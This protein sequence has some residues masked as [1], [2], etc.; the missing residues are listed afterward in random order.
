MD[1]IRTQRLEL[2]PMCMDYL[3]STHEYAGDPENTTYMMYLPN[4]TLED[5]VEYIKEAETE[6]AKDRPSFYEMAIFYNGNHIGAVSLYL[7]DDFATAAFGCVIN[8]KYHGSGFA[9]EAASGLLDYARQVLG[10]KHFIATCDTANIPSTRV[11][12]KIGMTR[13][14]ERGGRHNKQSPEERREYL[15][16]MWC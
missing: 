3:G 4:D 1:T 13:K 11:M 8:K 15:Y 14:A 7:E 10:I 6:F 9:A 5:T 16:E 12:E 2:R